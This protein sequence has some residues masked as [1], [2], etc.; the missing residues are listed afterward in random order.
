MPPIKVPY[1]SSTTVVC[2]KH[3]AM[4]FL[5][6]SLSFQNLNLMIFLRVSGLRFFDMLQNI[7]LILDYTY[8]A[9]WAAASVKK[10]NNKTTK[11]QTIFPLL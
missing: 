4:Q 5:S 6:D 9:A 8:H 1:S 11:P 2:L 3:K 7:V 10:K